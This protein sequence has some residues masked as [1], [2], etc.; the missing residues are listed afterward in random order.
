MTFSEKLITLRAG[1]GW[2]QERLAQELGI[3]RQAVGRWEKGS[4]LPDAKSLMALAR[5]FG[6]EAEWLLGEDADAVPQQTGSMRFELSVSALDWAMAALAIVG[7]LFYSAAMSLLAEYDSVALALF[8]NILYYCSYF[9]FGWLVRI[10]PLRLNG[11]AARICRIT[12]WA[13]LAFLTLVI[14]AYSAIVCAV[15]VP[16]G[17]ALYKVPS[18][19]ETLIH[20]IGSVMNRQEIFTVSGLLLGLGQRHRRAKNLP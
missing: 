13:L 18:G 15:I 10:L 7:M 8:A 2:S 9:A 4:G 20:I 16:S 6:V 11:G 12:G 19:F 1:R 14:A 5:V 17:D 3:T